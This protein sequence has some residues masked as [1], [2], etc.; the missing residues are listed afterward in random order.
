MYLIYRQVDLFH[1]P[2]YNEKIAIETSVFQCNRAI[3]SRNTVLLD[4]EGSVAMKDYEI[5]AFVDLERASM[6]RAP[7]EIVDAMMIDPPMEMER[8]P[9]KVAVPQGPCS[10]R[11]GTEFTVPRSYIDGF[12]H[13]NNSKYIE[14]TEPLLPDGFEVGRVRLEFKAAL[15]E[16]ETVVPMIY[17]NGSQATITL[18]APGQSVPRA[19]VEYTDASHC[20]QNKKAD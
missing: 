14:V 16:G 5:G 12:G 2:S 17:E 8:L 6:I 11:Q 19:V 3:G 9:R 10:Y 13:M 7:Q 4:K 1:R 15:L 18:M 20:C